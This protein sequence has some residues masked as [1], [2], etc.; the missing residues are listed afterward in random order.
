MK[1]LL[2]LAYFLYVQAECYYNQYGV[3][4]FCDECCYWYDGDWY[5]ETYQYCYTFI[6]ITVS[7]WIL[8]C[9]IYLSLY[10]Y[11]RNKT[12]QRI[13]L[14]HNRSAKAQR[15][16]IV[17]ETSKKNEIQNQTIEVATMDVQISNDQL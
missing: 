17:Q 5:C 16:N 4:H 2:L 15:E 7:I 9:L 12:I 10:F 3:L 13:T 8:I 6:A 14:I 11:V 1:I